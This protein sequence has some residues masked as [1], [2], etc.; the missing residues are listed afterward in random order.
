MCTDAFV[1]FR[2]PQESWFFSTSVSMLL[3]RGQVALCKRLPSGWFLSTRL[4]SL[5]TPG[6]L[7]AWW[8]WASEWGLNL[9]QEDIWSDRRGKLS[10]YLGVHV[11]SW[12]LSQ[13]C[14]WMRVVSCWTLCV[15]GFV[16]LNVPLPLWGLRS[17]FWSGCVWCCYGPLL[18]FSK[19]CPSVFWLLLF[20]LAAKIFCY[21]CGAGG[22]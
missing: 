17:T 4:T 3:W 11:T 15:R 8:F 5:L 9:Q 20:Y 19:M 13:C 6:Q 7:L 22:M 21:G 10:K 12:W 18:G 2:C 1:V 16:C 14:W